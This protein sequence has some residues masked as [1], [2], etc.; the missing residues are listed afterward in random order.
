MA[1]CE[2]VFIACSIFPIFGRVAGW[3]AGKSGDVRVCC[4]T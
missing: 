2:C 1:V 3:L 4:E